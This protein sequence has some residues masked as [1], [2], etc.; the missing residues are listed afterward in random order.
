MDNDH[1]GKYADLL[2]SIKGAILTVSIIACAFKLVCNSSSSALK[3]GSPICFS[4]LNGGK[5]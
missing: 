1:N 3:A 4:N 2:K 5:A